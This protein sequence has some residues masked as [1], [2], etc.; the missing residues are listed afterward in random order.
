[1]PPSGAKPPQFLVAMTLLGVDLARQR[2]ISIE[3]Q[4]SY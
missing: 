2:H 3:S 4:V 1:M